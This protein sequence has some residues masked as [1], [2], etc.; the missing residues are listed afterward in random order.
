M[1]STGSSR[2]LAITLMAAAV[3]LFADRDG[4]AALGETPLTKSP[5]DPDMD[6]ARS[7]EMAPARD[8]QEAV[9]E[10]FQLARKRGT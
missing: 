3:I 4:S 10:E 1:G 7:D 6:T 5:P 2:T 8:P 9:D